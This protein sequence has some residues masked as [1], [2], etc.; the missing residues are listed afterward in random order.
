MKLGVYYKHMTEKGSQGRILNLDIPYDET[1]SYFN[2]AE[3]EL[4]K[5][6][7]NEKVLIIA[8]SDGGIIMDVPPPVRAQTKRVRVELYRKECYFQDNLPL[9]FEWVK[10]DTKEGVVLSAFSKPPT[11]SQNI[12]TTLG[13]MTTPGEP[14][15]TYLIVGC[16]DGS[17]IETTLNYVTYLPDS[18]HGP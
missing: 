15:T 7:P 3:K 14:A 5:R 4:S 12:L 11:P 8:L 17:V 2:L 10:T 1:C 18:S 9:T 6:Y 16:D 13:M